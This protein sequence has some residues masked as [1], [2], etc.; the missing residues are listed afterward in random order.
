M[1]SNDLIETLLMPFLANR[2]YGLH[3]S[4]N[5]FSIGLTPIE[6]GCMR[7]QPLLIA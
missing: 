1:R 3:L 2:G 7:A 4:E 6:S 5:S